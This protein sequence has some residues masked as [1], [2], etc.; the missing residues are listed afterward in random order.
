M[1]GTERRDRPLCHLKVRQQTWQ[2]FEKV[3]SVSRRRWSADVGIADAISKPGALA[4]RHVQASHFS[5]RQ[6]RAVAEAD[7]LLP[8]PVPPRPCAPSYWP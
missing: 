3:K 8:W 6:F 4:R 5:R 7:K 2:G 1:Q